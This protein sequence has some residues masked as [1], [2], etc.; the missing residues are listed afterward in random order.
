MFFPREDAFC[1]NPGCP[2]GDLEPPPD[3]V[4]TSE[5]VGVR[6]TSARRASRAGCPRARRAGRSR[7]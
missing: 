3:P 5:S 6:S 2:G 1:R 4:P 7:R